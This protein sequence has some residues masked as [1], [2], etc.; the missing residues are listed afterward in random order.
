[1][2]DYKSS[3]GKR[4]SV[5]YYCIDCNHEY[6]EITFDKK[7]YKEVLVC[8]NCKGKVVDR[9]KVSKYAGGADFA[10]SKDFTVETQ[11]DINGTIKGLKAIQREAK[12]ATA[13]LKELEEQ[14]KESN[15]DVLIKTLAGL[16]GVPKEKLN[17]TEIKFTPLSKVEGFKPNEVVFDEMHSTCPKCGSTN[18]EIIEVK[19]APKELYARES[20]CLDCGYSI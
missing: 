17:N 14:K 16:H 3:E 20:K 5:I 2:A 1:M 6:R 12:K 18:T 9:W 8:P 19:S 4:M 7:E 11:L 13:S 10:H 15:R